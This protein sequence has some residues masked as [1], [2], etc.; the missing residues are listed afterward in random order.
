MSDSNTPDTVSPA[1]DQDGKLL[2]S[3]QEAD[4]LLRECLTLIKAPLH[5]MVLMSI[6][7]TNDLFERNEFVKEDVALT[8]RHM[9]G[10][11]VKR[12]DK[13]FNDLFEKRLAG[14]RRKVVAS[15][16]TRRSRALRVLNSFDQEQQA[17]LT[18][19]AFHLFRM[20]RRECNALDLRIAVL[21]REPR[22]Q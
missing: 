3:A 17:A 20:T 21:L 19:S 18:K 4:A 13:A 6:E 14:G 7:T 16:M 22:A 15:T 10:E 9:R 5:D 1:T 2:L 11:W 12:F 8:F